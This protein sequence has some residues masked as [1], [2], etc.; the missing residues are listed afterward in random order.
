MAIVATHVQAVQNL[1]V[2]YFGRPADT[3]GLDYWTNV[4][5]ANAGVTTAVSA[6]FAKETEYT[7]LFKGLNNGQVVDKIYANMFGHAADAA[8]RAYWVKLLDDKV[9]TI[10][11]VV[12]EV[13]KGAQT[14][15]KE[16]VENK[17]AAAVAFTAALDTAEEQ[18]GYNGANALPVAK[19]FLAGITTDATLATAIAPAALNATVS[20]VVIAGTPF[21]VNG[22]L[23]RLETA[24]KAEAAFL[25]TADGDNSAATSATEASLDAA[26]VTKAGLVAAAL[27]AASATTYTNGSAAVKAAVVAD[28]Q[29][30]FTTTLATQQAAVVTAN[31]EIAKVTGLQAA[32]TTLSGAIAAQ[33]AATT[34][35]NSATSDLTGKVAFY[36]LTNGPDITVAADGTVT[37]LITANA[38]G[39][40]SLAAGVTETTNPGI[41]AVLNAS[42]AVE[43]AEKALINATSVV[44]AAQ[45]T[46]DF[47]D[48]NATQEAALTALKAEMTSFT[49][50]TG[51]QPTQAQINEQIEIFRVGDVANPSSTVYEDF[52]D[53]VAT[54]R[55]AAAAN[56]PLNT[57]L[58][59]AEGAVKTT[60]AS[61]KALNDAVTGLSTAEANVTQYDALHASVM[62]ATK[63]FT[64]NGYALQNVDTAF[65]IGS[66]SSD[67][68]MVGK[69]SSS[70]SLFGLQGADALYVGNGYT[71]NTGAL[72]TGNNAALEAFVSQSGLDTVIRVETSAFGSSA[73]TP[74]LVTITL[75]GVDATDIQMNNGIIT[76]VTGG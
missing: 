7:D 6:A 43:G 68:F 67:I 18:A 53:D 31:N 11:T 69:T 16:T 19:A 14:T 27:P 57:G 58:T 71:L 34:V 15:D 39:K 54:F 10:D 2:A 37:G 17:G 33:T 65:E 52:L 23:A 20:A 59:T 32:V 38:A 73:S 44:T 63:V 22:A 51:V 64:D 76:V 29:N 47:L 70:I 24:Q 56:N 25:V 60:T 26:V 5:E 21:S 3:A 8:G 12:A 35:Q 72:S 30:A 48:T 9:I 42:T 50:A 45:Q 55:T 28:Q 40:L 46:V 75:V 61:I 13:A 1:Y 62:T 74:E 4:V 49:F 36:N 41:T 66:A